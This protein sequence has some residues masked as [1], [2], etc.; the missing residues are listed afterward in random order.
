MKNDIVHS[1]LK[2]P[3]C[4]YKEERKIHRY[5]YRQTCI[6]IKTSCKFDTYISVLSAFLHWIFDK[7]LKQII[8]SNKYAD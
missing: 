4:M 7:Y 5:R 2:I 3:E 1:I 8:Y 6:H